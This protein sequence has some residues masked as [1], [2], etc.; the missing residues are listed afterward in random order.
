MGT[1]GHAVA[2][3]LGHESF[4]ATEHHHAKAAAIDQSAERC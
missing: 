4:T 3:A 2:L 1:T